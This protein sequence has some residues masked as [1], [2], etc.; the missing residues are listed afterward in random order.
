MQQPTFN[1]Q[2]LLMMGAAIFVSVTAAVIVSTLVIMSLMRGEIASAL[3]SQVYNEAPVTAQTTSA[4]CSV[5]ASEISDG[6][7]ASAS[8]GTAATG[9]YAAPLTGSVHFAKYMPVA[10]S[11]SF[12]NT[13]NNTV[14][15]NVSNTEFNSKTV[16]KDSYNDNSNTVVVKDNTVNVNSNNNNSTNSGNTTN[17]TQNNVQTTNNLTTTTNITSNINSNNTT[18]VASNNTTN[19]ASNNTYENHVLSDNVVVVPKV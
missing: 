14:T 8:T 19:V 9:N 5:P 4:G 11:H 10:T 18:N 3:T 2:S 16:V 6:G 17:N 1:S 15:N 13:T 7:E 12:N